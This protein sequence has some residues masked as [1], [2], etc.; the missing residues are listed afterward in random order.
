MEELTKEWL[1]KN[2]IIYD[3]LIF[4]GNKEKLQ[5][6]MDNNVDIMIEDSPDNII[7]ISSKIP[8]IKYYCRYN[9]D[10]QGKNIITGY[11]WYHIYDIIKNYQR[12]K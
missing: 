12:D 4:A 11:S 3:K 6:C 1:R 5:Q 2:N 7:N 8:V 9:K 10:I